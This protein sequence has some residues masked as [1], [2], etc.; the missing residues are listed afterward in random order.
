VKAFAYVNAANEKDAI[1]AL[2]PDRGK[3][4][5]L[6]G[7]MDVLALMKDYILAPERLVNVKNLDRTIARTSDGGLRIGAAV[8]LTDLVEHADLARMYPAFVQAAADVGTPQIRNAGTVGGNLNQR[9]RCWYFRNEEFNCLKKG[10]SRCFAVDGENQYHAIFGEGPCHIIHPSSLAV[11]AIALGAHF[12][13]VGPAGERDVSA[14]QYFVMPDR[15][16]FGETVLQPNELL[17]HVIL[18]PPRNAKSATY[19]VRY[20]QSHDWPLATAS[21]VLDMNGNTIRGARVVMGAVAPVPWRS[22][23]AEQALTGKSVSEE[24]AMAAADAAVTGAKPMSGNKYKVQI[25]RTTVKRAI[26]KAGGMKAN[27]W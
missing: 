5:P 16:L 10:G 14:D 18:P 26:L 7:G 24:I 3:F 25:A 22:Q 8:T 9:P 21:V 11:P 12:R 4:L 27:W 15:N 6:A 19:E 20:K 23:A 1:A 13:V 17:T 2:G